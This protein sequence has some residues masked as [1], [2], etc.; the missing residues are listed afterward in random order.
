NVLDLATR[1][2]VAV[3]SKLG[4]NR[5]SFVLKEFLETQRDH[6][7]AL[8]ESLRS[9]LREELQSFA[10]VVEDNLFAI[11][12]Q[13]PAPELRAPRRAPAARCPGTMPDT[14]RTGRADRD[15]AKRARRRS[16]R[17][18]RR[19]SRPAATRSSI[20]SGGSPSRRTTGA[21]R[22]R[23]ARGRARPS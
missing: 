10:A 19:R 22:S 11:D 18:N 14:P 16:A 21:G 6:D 4:R 1:D 7:E 3:Q 17:A 5:V 12:E 2:D 15:S 8:L 9:E 23:V 13:P 20:D